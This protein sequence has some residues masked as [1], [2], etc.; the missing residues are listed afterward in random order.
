MSP[1]SLPGPDAQ[2][3]LPGPPENV[4]LRAVRNNPDHARG[5]AERWRRIEASG[6][7]IHGEGRLVDAMAP[8][9]AAILDAGCGSGRIGGYL[10]RAGH[11]VT[12]VDLDEHLIEVAREDHPGARWEVGNLAELDLRSPEQSSPDPSAPVQSGLDQRSPEQ[13]A[14]E[15]AGRALFDLIVSAGNVMT[16]LAG[17]ERRPALSR[18]REH[19]AEGGRIVLGF[20]LDRGY[21]LEDFEADVAA[22]ELVIS[23]RF[24]GWDLHPPEHDPGFL[25]AVLTRP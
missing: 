15:Q 4:W 1:I 25:V 23:Q 20:G 9:G 19:L 16:F 2:C 6:Q 10:A 13:S 11:R 14:P 12:G 3:P 24:A 8:R 7:D 22:S 17:S 18:M 21:E 5:Y